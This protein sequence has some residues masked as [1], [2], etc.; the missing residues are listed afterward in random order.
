[1]SKESVRPIYPVKIVD[2]ACENCKYCDDFDRVCT[3]GKSPNRFEFTFNT[4]ACSQWEEI[5]NESI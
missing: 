3:N 2:K 5:A 4:K 1:M